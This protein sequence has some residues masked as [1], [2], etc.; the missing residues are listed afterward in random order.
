MLLSRLHATATNA[1]AVSS[2]AARQKRLHDRSRNKTAD[3]GGGHGNAS[4]ASVGGDEDP[5]FRSDSPFPWGAALV[6]AACGAV[7]YKVSNVVA[8]GMFVPVVNGV[9]MVCLAAFAFHKLKE[10]GTFEGGRGKRGDQRQ[11]YRQQHR[12]VGGGGGVARKG[13]AWRRRGRSQ[14]GGSGGAGGS[15]YLFG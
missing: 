10:K 13:E 4:A 9:F 6:A 5:S 12:A 8:V 14:G 1:S 2:A 11:R 3:G 15:T 7:Y